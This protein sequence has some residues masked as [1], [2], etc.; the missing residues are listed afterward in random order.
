MK[1]PI[2]DEHKRLVKEFGASYT[3]DLKDFP[4]YRGFESGLLFSHRDFDEFFKKLK[5][6][7]KVAIVSG[8]NPSSALHLG[9]KGVFDTNLFFQEKYNVDVF[10]PLSDD[11]SYLAGK[12]QD[13]K[14]GLKNARHLVKQLLAI[15]FNP[16]KT[17]FIID[18]IYTEIYNLAIKFSRLVTRST[19]KATYGHSEE[20]NIGLQFYPCVQA[21]HILLPLYL[22]YKHVLVPISIDEDMHIRISRDIAGKLNLPKPSVLHSAFMPGIDG[23]KMSKS[24]PESAIFLDD[25][26]KLVKKKV[27]RAFSGGRGTVE[28]HRRLGGIPEQDVALK[29]LT[30]YFLDK[31]EADKLEKDYKAGKI[32]SAEL[33]E[34]LYEELEKFLVDYKK[35]LAKITEKDVDAVLMRNENCKLI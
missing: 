35:K 10:I 14:T 17:K 2:D 23:E 22:G 18:Q 3:K 1:I 29:Y 21:A 13:Q 27:M 8:L 5:K 31:K 19:I 6:G 9:H 30:A 12:I 26:L 4:K 7:E 25:D 15:G 16:K 33:K 34:K 20:V 28:E 11:E 32:L 24:R